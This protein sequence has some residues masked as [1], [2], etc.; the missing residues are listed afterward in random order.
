M[1]DAPA[2]ANGGWGIPKIRQKKGHKGH[3]VVQR[4]PPDIAI[5]L[6]QAAAKAAIIA[7]VN[8]LLL[9]GQLLQIGNDI[10]KHPFHPFCSIAIHYNL[11]SIVCLE[12]FVNLIYH[13][14]AP[15]HILN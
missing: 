6:F 7:A 3:I 1:D 14:P 5:L 8:F 10:S 11:F 4:Q 9:F 2:L 13:I 15:L 12:Q